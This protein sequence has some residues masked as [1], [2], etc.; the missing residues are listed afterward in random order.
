MT[1]RLSILAASPWPAGDEPPAVSTLPELIGYQA[2]R[3]PDAGA[4]VAGDKRYSYRELDDE[5]ARVA[6]GLSLLGVGAGSHVAVLIP[7][8]AEWAVTAFAILR[9]GGVVESFNTWVKAY[10]LRHLLASSRAQLLV[11]APSVRGGDLLAELRELAPD[12]WQSGR[13]RE[14]PSL[15]RVV[16]LPGESPTPPP[17]G[18]LPYADLLVDGEVPPIAAVGSGTAYVLYTSGTTSLPKAVPLAHRALIENGYSIG[19]RMGLDESDRVWLGSPLFWSYGCANAAMATFGHGACLVLQERF[20]PKEA[21]ELMRRERVTAAYLLPSITRAFEQ[22][23]LAEIRAVATLRT[24]L[25]IGTPEE[26][27]RTA[28][29]LDIPELCN[30]YGSTETYGNCCVTPH[31]LPLEERMVSQ[32]PPLSGV[33][34]RIA[35]TETG[36][37]VPFGEVGEFQ[38]RGRI[39]AGYVGSPEATAESMTSDGWFRTGDTGRLIDGG[40][41]QFVGRATDMIKTS[42]INVSPAELESFISTHPSVVEVGVVGAPHPTRDEVTVAFVVRKP[43]D[44]LTAQD[45]I[46]FCKRSLSGYK[47]PWAVDFLDALPGTATGKMLRRELREPAKALVDKLLTQ[48]ERA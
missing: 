42:G 12:L 4:L 23:A 44:E 29:D 20:T 9:L 10:D 19:S 11:M 22:E 41:V 34:L 39:M 45:V 27:R 16:L 18:A 38:V 26:F 32:G 37:I 5:I 1:D 46:D 31:T 48:K 30:V 43:G 15:E 33:E 35:D 13:S 3:I 8:V 28:V 36:E 2:A 21:A 14:F 6:T 25:V 47:V 24:G 7:N 17:P 40:M